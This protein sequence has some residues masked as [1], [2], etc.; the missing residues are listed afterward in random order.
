MAL[1][2]E[3]ARQSRGAALGTCWAIQSLKLYRELA[4]QSCGISYYTCRLPCNNM[5][6][7]TE[8]TGV[9][10]ELG[11]GIAIPIEHQYTRALK[12]SGDLR[13]SGASSTGAEK[14]QLV[15]GKQRA[16]AREVECEKHRQH[17]KTIS[18]TTAGEQNLTNNFR[19][20][21]GRSSKCNS[22][23]SYFPTE[24]VLNHRLGSDY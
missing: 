24:N 7:T 4:M 5:V 8:P 2:I 18:N 16:Q 13:K 3:I 10:R 1:H 20:G 22:L 17:A 6:L 12:A 23:A 9:H 19:A 11:F 14:I 15:R 21:K